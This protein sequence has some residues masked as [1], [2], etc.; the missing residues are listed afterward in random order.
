LMAPFHTA[1]TAMISSGLAATKRVRALPG[2][3]L[4]RFVGE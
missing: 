4:E 2:S 1:R 3:W